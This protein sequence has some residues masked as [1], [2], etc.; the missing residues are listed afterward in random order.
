MSETSVTINAIAE[1]L[2]ALNDAIAQHAAAGYGSHT[3]VLV[4]HDITHAVVV[5]VDGIVQECGAQPAIDEAFMARHSVG[6]DDD[7]WRAR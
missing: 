4:P 1:R 5:T 2:A 3:L 6:A 7:T